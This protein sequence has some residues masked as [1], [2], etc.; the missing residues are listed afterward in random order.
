MGQ[1][2]ATAERIVRAPADRVRS[3]LADYTETRRREHPEQFSE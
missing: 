1:V 2:V 3:A